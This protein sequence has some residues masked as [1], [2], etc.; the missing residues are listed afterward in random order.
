M[1]QFAFGEKRVGF[2]QCCDN[3]AIGIA[4]FTIFVQN[5]LAGK[6]RYMVEIDTRFINCEGNLYLVL[7]TK[8]K[9][10]LTMPGGNMYKPRACF[11]S[12]KISGQYRHVKIITLSCKRMGANQA[13]RF[14]ISQALEISYI[15]G[16]HGAFGKVI[17]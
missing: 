11:C 6:N 13:F 9:V 10:I 12:H 3:S 14:N 4:V 5:F 8:F 16:I 1:T 2:N 15:G 17:T 7:Q